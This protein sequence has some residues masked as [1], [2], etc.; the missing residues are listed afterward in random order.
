MQIFAKLAHVM[1]MGNAGLRGAGFTFSAA[2][3]HVLFLHDAITSTNFPM[4]QEMQLVMCSL[5]EVSG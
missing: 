4:T 3:S 1:E 2:I 5:R